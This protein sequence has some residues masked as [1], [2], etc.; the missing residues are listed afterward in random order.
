MFKA[1][2]G[3]EHMSAC[4]GR[5]S[6]LW[7]FSLP[8]VLPYP[9]PQLLRGHAGVGT[10]IGQPGCLLLGEWIIKCGAYTVKCHAKVR[11]NELR[12]IH[13]HGWTF[14]SV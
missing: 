9:P 5:L 12:C 8:T 11:N 1:M 13:K 2:C 6:S 4:A 3:M 7:V 14:I 10:N